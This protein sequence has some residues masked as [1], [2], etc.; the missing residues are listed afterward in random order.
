MSLAAKRGIAAGTTVVAAAAVNIATGMLTQHWATAWWATLGVILIGNVV[1]QVYLTVA[2][3][4]PAPSNSISITGD[5]SG[6]VNTGDGASIVQ[7][8]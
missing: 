8:R 1:A 6:V 4:N 7:N 2:G 5:V 3:S